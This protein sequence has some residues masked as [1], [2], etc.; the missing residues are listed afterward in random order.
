MYLVSREKSDL[1][2][3]FEGG[4]ALSVD[5]FASLRR[6][7]DRMLG[8]V[9]PNT[10]KRVVSIYGGFTGDLFVYYCPVDVLVPAEI[11]SNDGV[12]KFTY[13]PPNKFYRTSDTSLFTLEYVNG[14]RFLVARHSSVGGSE[15]LDTMENISN[16]T[17]TGVTL[18]LNSHDVLFGTYT[19]QGTFTAANGTISGTFASTDITAK[20]WGIARLAVNLSDAATVTNIKLRLYSS[21]TDYFEMTTSTDSVND[22]LIA[23]WNMLRFDMATRTETGSP[24]S[25]A[26]LKWAL[27]FALTD[28]TTI[29][30]DELVL[31]ETEKMYLEYISNRLFVDGTTRQWK[32]EPESDAD[33]INL[34]RDSSS[35]LHFEAARL[36]GKKP[37]AGLNFTDELAREYQQYWEKHPSDAQ[38]LSYN[39]SSEV[40]I[41]APTAFDL[42]QTEDISAEIEAS[43]SFMNGIT[44]TGTQDGN[45][46]V[47]TLP[48]TPDPASSLQ[49]FYNGQ[50]M[51]EGSDFTLSGSTI[52]MNF[53]PAVG[54]SFIAYFQY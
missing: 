15:T 2:A 30:L 40:G 32:E 23:G 39:V 53:A 13:V 34:D 17:A 1:K 25:T 41:N 42:S 8:Q 11:Y 18:S 16:K 54:V 47:F 28:D 26:V 5:W 52:T 46:T 12:R 21:D 44:P 29:I 49:L 4:K 35:I 51:T 45:N 7:A 19:V 27:I 10:L 33:Y 48:V 50:Y 36:I 9:Y 3:E 31:Q 22:S 6:A 43:V 38:P 20:L 14:V 24:D 37:I